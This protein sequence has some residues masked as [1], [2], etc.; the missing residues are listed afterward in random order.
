L[1]ALSERD[2]L[3]FVK[4]NTPAA[5]AQTATA[6]DGTGIYY[7]ELGD[8]ARPPVFLGPHCYASSLEG[9]QVGDAPAEVTQGWV[10]V[11]EDRF[12]VI[13]ADYPRG[14]GRTG[15]PLGLDYTAAVA[16][17]DFEALLDAAD[18]ERAGFL[19]Y[20]YGAA[21]GLQ[22]ACRSGRVSALA[23][24]GWPPLEA[25]Y[26]RLAEIV[27]EGATN[28]P[29]EIEPAL[30]WSVVGFYGSLVDWP[31]RDE[32]PKIDVPRLAYAGTGDEIGWPG[33]SIAERLRGVEADLRALGWQT[34]WID[35]QDHAGAMD[36]GVAGPMVRDFLEAGL[37]G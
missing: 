11:L 27:T 34:A 13:V 8:P 6:R 28:P 32:V 37:C 9:I 18:V 31:E 36:P 20:S 3:A 26:R 33:P 24:G 15:N 29:A 25:P 17:E 21:L 2:T 10:G 19:G 16:V 7:V 5:H 23:M 35:G 30:L 14:L 4:S 22:A 12:R 1:F